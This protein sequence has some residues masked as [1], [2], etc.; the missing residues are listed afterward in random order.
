MK[1]I[2]RNKCKR[3][4]KEAETLVRSDLHSHVKKFKSEFTVGLDKFILIILIPFLLKESL[5]FAS[6]MPKGNFA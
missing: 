1:K 4:I 2:K 5:L 3:N 6:N